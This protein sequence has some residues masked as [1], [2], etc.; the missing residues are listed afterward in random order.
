MK[1]EID[2]DDTLDNIVAKVT[3]LKKEQNKFTFRTSFEREFTHSPYNGVSIDI[4]TK[5]HKVN[6]EFVPA[7]SFTRGDFDGFINFLYKIKSLMK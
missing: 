3:K 7:G 5:L 1:V 6:K 2:L 4:R